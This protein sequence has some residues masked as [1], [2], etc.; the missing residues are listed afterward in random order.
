MSKVST[1]SWTT[2]ALPVAVMLMP[3][4]AKIVPCQLSIWMLFRSADL[5]QVMK[6]LGSYWA[7]MAAIRS[8]S[9][10]RQMKPIYF[11]G[12]VNLGAGSIRSYSIRRSILA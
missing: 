8:V 10:R 11:L 6:M 9:K 2:V 1:G 4:V 7:L 3:L 5:P 12:T